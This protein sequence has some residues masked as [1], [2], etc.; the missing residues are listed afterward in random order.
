MADEDL[1]T[2]DT[3]LDDD[4]T[5]TGEAHE[6]IHVEP[7]LTGDNN[8]GTVPPTAAADV[9]SEPEPGPAVPRRALED[10]RRKRQEL[11][12]KLAEYQERFTPQPMQ[13]PAMQPYQ[14]MPQQPEAIPDP[15]LEPDAFRH[16]QH[17]QVETYVERMQRET[18]A[19]EYQRGVIMSDMQMRAQHDD[20]DELVNVAVEVAKQ[21]PQLAHL[22][23]SHPLPG[24]AAYQAGQKLKA[25]QE[26]GDPTSYRAKVEAEVLAK[27]GIQPNG[28]AQP[29]KLKAPVPRSLAGH[30]S[31]Q[32]RDHAG[33]FSEVSLEDILDD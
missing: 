27:Y 15:I 14:Q 5:A 11:E 4:A 29:A 12:R 13:Q 2:L 23:T 30:G 9:E 20:Y 21:D 3:L 24:V 7:E 31:K 1:D 28:A 33:R 26:I 10:E 8:E 18:Q 6:P 19:R 22:I 17:Q 32:P 16:W 25:M